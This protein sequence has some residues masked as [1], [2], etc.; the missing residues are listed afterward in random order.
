VLP[1]PD[2]V[3]SK[4]PA[5]ASSPDMTIRGL[6]APSTAWRYT[7]AAG[8]L[9]GYVA[10]Y[11]T[12]SGKEIRCWTWGAKGDTEPRW[13][14]GHWSKPRPLYGLHRL[15]QQPTAPVLIVEGEKAA[16]AAQLL[17]PHY[18]VIT[19]PGGAKAWK[20][21]DWAPLRG[22]RCDLWPDNDEAG[23]GAMRALQAILEDFL[24]RQVYRASRHGRRL[25][26]RRLGARSGYHAVASRSSN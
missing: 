19:W 25:R 17:L 3:T 1:P 9:L 14:C 15:A 11:D 18:A 5:T 23:V 4:P 22:R 6:G 20:H 10:R 7:D 21:A 26:R 13:G 12:D 24:P 2:R 16:D 8:D